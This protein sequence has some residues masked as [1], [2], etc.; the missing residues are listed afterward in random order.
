M[1][2]GAETRLESPACG[3]FG[4]CVMS[5]RDEYRQFA[6]ECLRFAAEAKDHGRRK[7]F[8]EMADAW[9]VVALV[10]APAVVKHADSPS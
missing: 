10:D 4:Y 6:E 7:I 3:I 1:E 2:P 8:L 5:I 9:T